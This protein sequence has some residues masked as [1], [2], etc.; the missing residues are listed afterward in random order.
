MVRAKGD[1]AFTALLKK[2]HEDGVAY[3]VAELERNL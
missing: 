3:T 2:R 1:A